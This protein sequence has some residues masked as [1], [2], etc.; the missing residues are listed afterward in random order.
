MIEALFNQTNYVAAKKMLDATVLRHQAL[1][2]NLANIETPGYKRVDI[3]PD[4]NQELG[5]AMATQSPA[6]IKQLTP[7][8]QVDTTATARGLDGNT[9]GLE[10]EM[11]QMNQNTLAHTV[12]T[13]MITASLV[14]LRMA[15]TGKS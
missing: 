6:Q 11:M 7:H 15:I 10:D 5:K 9:V 8:I 3:S 14:R 12:E 2:G 4:F 13:Q 1:A